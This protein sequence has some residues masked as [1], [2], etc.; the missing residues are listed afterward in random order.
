MTENMKKF[1]SRISEDQE[2]AEK[3]SKAEKE[4]MIAEAKE[5]GVELTDADFAPEENVLSED[6]LEA[7]AGGA[8]CSCVVGGGGKKDEAI[9]DKACGCAFYGQ[10]NN[11]NGNGR[12]L[13]PLSGAGYASDT[14]YS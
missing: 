14:G 11:K 7:V 5:M 6:E 8:Q 12:C 2:L 10:G 1:L 13:C 4:A 3:L 9:G